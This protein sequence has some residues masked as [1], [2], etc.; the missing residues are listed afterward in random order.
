LVLRYGSSV[1]SLLNFLERQGRLVQ[2]E[3]DRYYDRN[4]V[5]A[6][7]AKLRAGLAPGRVYAPAQLR[8][9]LGFSRKYLIPFLEF[10]DRIGVTERRGEGRTLRQTPGI[11]L[12][13]FRTQ[14]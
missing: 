5:D 6:L 12:D 8:D 9:L 2:V 10:C 4:A 3:A 13:S 14:P 7:I 11:L 1:P